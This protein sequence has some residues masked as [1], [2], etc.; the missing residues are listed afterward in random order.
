MFFRNHS[1]IDYSLLVLLVD[2]RSLKSHLLATHRLDEL[3]L[4][5]HIERPG[6]HCQLTYLPS[7]E[8]GMYYHIALIDYL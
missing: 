7:E 4:L 5:E 2:H 6:K 1:I 8:P 3:Y